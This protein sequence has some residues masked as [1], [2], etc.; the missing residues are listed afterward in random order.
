MQVTIA[1]QLGLD[2]STVSNFFM[3]ARR[4]SV[5][6]WRD[7]TLDHGGDH[8]TGSIEDDDG[9]GGAVC[10]DFDDEELVDSP[11]MPQQHQQPLQAQAQQQQMQQVQVQPTAAIMTSGGQTIA[12]TRAAV[13][14]GQT[15]LL[16][17]PQT[18]GGGGAV[19]QQIHA[20]DLGQQ[21]QDLEL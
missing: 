14:G 16:A 8:D 7:D 17:A 1:K 13:V 10:D 21:G 4:R 9:S 3:N 2:P 15:V 18:G 5:D 20:V 11:G 6:K 12:L 19:V